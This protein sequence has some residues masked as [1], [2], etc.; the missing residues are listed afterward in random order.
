MLLTAL[1]S[2]TELFGFNKSDEL[3]KINEGLSG[4]VPLLGKMKPDNIADGD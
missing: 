2:I 3:K 1:N 4:L